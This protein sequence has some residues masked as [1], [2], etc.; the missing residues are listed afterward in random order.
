MAS[1]GKASVVWELSEL[2][3]EDGVVVV[4]VD[5]PLRPFGTVPTPPR[6][7]ARESAMRNVPHTN[8]AAKEGTEPDGAPVDD[9]ALPPRAPKPTR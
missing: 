8:P 4:D 6:G 1:R 5:A 2:S 7:T 3:A 9:L